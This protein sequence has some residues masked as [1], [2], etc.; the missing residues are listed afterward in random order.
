MNG[1]MAAF[2]DK[3]QG[4]VTRRTESVWAEVEEL[5]EQYPD[6]DK[7]YSEKLTALY[8]SVGLY[9]YAIRPLVV[10]VAAVAYQLAVGRGAKDPWTNTKVVAAR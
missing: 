3:W 8:R 1:V 4:E 2:N 7:T 6:D 9:K 5:R 10:V